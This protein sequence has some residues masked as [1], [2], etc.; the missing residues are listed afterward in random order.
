MTPITYTDVYSVGL[1]GIT[2]RSGEALVTMHV[3]D[4]DGVETVS[5]DRG[6]RL[7]ALSSADH[8]LH[9][10][11]VRAV[12]TAGLAPTSVTATPLERIAGDDHLSVEEKAVLGMTPEPPAPPA[13]AAI[14]TVQRLTVRVTDG[15]EPDRI[16]VAAG[17]PVELTFTEGHGCLGRVVFEGLGI[18]A[19]LEQ[20]GAVVSLPALEPGEYPFSCGMHMVHGTL[21][22][23]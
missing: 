11:I 9:D 18:E 12:V 7:V 13:R 2:C 16:I 15:Y 19:D 22:A 21:V 10:E 14:Q 20:G 1:E 17:I 6:R 5:I 23:E 3:L 4:I 8:D